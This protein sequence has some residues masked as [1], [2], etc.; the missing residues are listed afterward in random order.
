MTR[1][2]KAIDPKKLT[3]DVRQMKSV[4]ME[5]KDF[6]TP[7]VQEAGQAI[8]EVE[9][10]ECLQAGRHERSDQRLGYRSGYYRRRL[11]TRVGTLV[12]REQLKPM[13][14]AMSIAA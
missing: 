10:S 13:K 4:L 3:I 8:L 2:K 14:A 11:L 6:L 9:M 7:V 1:K 5:Q 12:L